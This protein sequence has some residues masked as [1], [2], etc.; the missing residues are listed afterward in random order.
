[1]KRDRRIGVLSRMLKMLV[2]EQFE[3]K[4]FQWNHHFVD[5][6]RLVRNADKNLG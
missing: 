2:R 5:K 3:N 1:M 4:I 6:S